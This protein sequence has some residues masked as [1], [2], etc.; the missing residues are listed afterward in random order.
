M[1]SPSTQ[2][3]FS[4]VVGGERG[5]THF[6]S[7]TEPH[8]QLLGVSGGQHQRHQL[9]VN[10]QHQQMMNYESNSYHHHPPHSHSP[11]SLLSHT[12]SPHHP[13]PDSLTNNTNEH[14]IDYQPPSLPHMSK[15]SLPPNAG[16]P[17]SQ[18]QSPGL[19]H[20][21]VPGSLPPPLNPVGGVG[22]N[23]ASPPRLHRLAPPGG[24][25]GGGGSSQNHHSYH[26]SG[27]VASQN[28][29]QRTQQVS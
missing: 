14:L 5:G 21:S 17:P 4:P 18:Q 1:P 24:S 9:W 3:A 26:Q 20:Q 28:V 2:S 13:V 12:H 8:Q 25:G 19:A 7:T 27:L 22:I 11:H 10:S 23:S 16:V 6:P 15:F 29:T